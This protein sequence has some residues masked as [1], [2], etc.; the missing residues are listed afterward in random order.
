MNCLFC[1]KTADRPRCLTGG[2]YAPAGSQVGRIS[3]DLCIR[4][5]PVHSGGDNRLLWSFAVNPRCQIDLLRADAFFWLPLNINQLG[6]EQ[7]HWRSGNFTF[8]GRYGTGGG[9]PALLGSRFVPWAAMAE[10]KTSTDT[11]ATFQS[12]HL[13]SFSP[14]QLPHLPG[15]GSPDHLPKDLPGCLS[16]MTAELGS[17]ARLRCV[18]KLHPKHTKDAVSWAVTNEPQFKTRVDERMNNPKDSCVRPF[19]L[20]HGFL[21]RQH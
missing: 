18:F 9:L 3:C 16:K 15:A 11:V 4:Q 10:P 21:R 17:L 20:S 1:H 8:W 13:I 19:S 14:P 6:K 5:A 2:V 12:R 7:I